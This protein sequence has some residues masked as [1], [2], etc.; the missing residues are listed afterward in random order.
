MPSSPLI[1]ADRIADYASFTDESCSDGNNRFMVIGG[2]LCRSYEAHQFSAQ[3]AKIKADCP[4]R[5]SIQFK[6]LNK[7][8]FATAKRMVDLF[9]DGYASRRLDF[10]CIVFDQRKFDHVKFNDGDAEKGF[11]KFLFQHYN[12]HRR[13]FGHE[14]CFRCFHGNKDTSYD[15]RE[16]RR[17]LNNMASLEFGARIAPY[18]LVELAEVRRT[19]MLQLADLLLGCV[20]HAM[21]GRGLMNPDAP[22]ARLAEYLRTECPVDALNR[23]TTSPDRGFSIWHFDLDRARGPSPSGHQDHKAH[24]PFRTP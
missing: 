16:L 19:N 23:P 11:F 1:G 3:I 4:F 24:D 14:A 8:K 20:G 5:E 17:A 21:H 2:V 10:G 9:L 7:V 22:K 18:R 12:K 13:S 6:S 15:M